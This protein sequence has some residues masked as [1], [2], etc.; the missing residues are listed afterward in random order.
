MT[1]KAPHLHHLASIRKY[2]QKKMLFMGATPQARHHEE[3][4]RSK[5]LS[6]TFSSFNKEN[7][8][9][10]PNYGIDRKTYM[11]I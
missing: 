11:D 4:E 10:D 8:L 2:F 7:L 6:V 3:A 1:I 9:R 5:T